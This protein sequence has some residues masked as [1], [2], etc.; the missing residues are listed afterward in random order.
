MTDRRLTDLTGARPKIAQLLE[1]LGAQAGLRLT[2]TISEA[3]PQ[4]PAQPEPA[5][6]TDQTEPEISVDLSGPD[7]PLLL[8]RNAELLHAIEH[9]A[10]K[11]L[12]LEPEEH[13]RISFDAAQFKANRDRQLRRATETAIATVLAEGRPYTFPAMSSRER[14]LLHLAISPSG[15][16]SASTGEGPRRSV[17]IYPPTHPPTA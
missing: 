15:L 11:I 6:P 14:R 2:A 10:A 12:R 9:I 4:L 16:R 1:L 17:V 5:Q 8:A 7:T 3:A 13:D